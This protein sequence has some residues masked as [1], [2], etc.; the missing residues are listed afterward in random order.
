MQ[1]VETQRQDASLKSLTVTFLQRA[2]ENNLWA[3]PFGR[4]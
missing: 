1:K 4:S 3:S 2:N